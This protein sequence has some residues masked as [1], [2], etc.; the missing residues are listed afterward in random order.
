VLAG[1]GYQELQQLLQAQGTQPRGQREFWGLLALT[2]FREHVQQPLLAWGTKPAVCSF[3]Y[4]WS[5]KPWALLTWR[6][7]GFPDVLE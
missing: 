3:C 1:I 6:G 5:S 7:T 4:L 2:G